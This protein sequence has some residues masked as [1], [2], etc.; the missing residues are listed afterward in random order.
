[1]RKSPPSAGSQVLEETKEEAKTEATPGDI[2]CKN[3]F[4]NVI[5]DKEGTPEI[6]FKDE[7]SDSDKEEVM[8]SLHQEALRKGITADPMDFDSLAV[9]LL[10]SVAIQDDD[11]LFSVNYK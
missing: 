10:G 7:S 9:G 4:P 11:D 6:T 8:K 5:T 3:E 2:D 1:M